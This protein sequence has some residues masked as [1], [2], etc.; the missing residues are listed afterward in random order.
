MRTNSA[1]LNAVGNTPLLPLERIGGDYSILAKMELKNPGGSVKDRPARA[2][3]LDGIRSGKLRDGMRILD[4]TSGNTGIAYGWIGATLGVGVTL[5]IP[6]NASPERF[7]ILSALGVEVIK[8]NPL[9]ATD[10]AQKV[11]KEM[12]AENPGK[13]FYPD[14]YGNDANW[15]SHF[16]STGPEIWTQSNKSITHFVSVLGTTGTFVGVSRYLKSVSPSIHIVEIQPDSPFHGLEGIKHLPSVN[17]PRIYDEKVKNE[18][19]EVSTE[20]AQEMCRRLAR[21]EGVLVGPSSGANVV[22][23]RR[24]GEQHKG[25]VVATIL[26]DDGSRYLQDEFWKC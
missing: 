22:V 7:A 14:Q 5:C 4:A 15:R 19:V 24:I 17:I 16:E 2:M 26:C 8:T 25:A 18:L 13:W 10:G 6:G 11:A 12:H 9:E 1:L 3:I 23:A 20:D 21:E